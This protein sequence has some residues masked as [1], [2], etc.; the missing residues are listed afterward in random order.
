MGGSA[1]ERKVPDKRDVAGMQSKEPLEPSGAGAGGKAGRDTSV[2]NKKRKRPEAWAGA[3]VR[4][5]D[6]G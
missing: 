3:E 4:V 1:G 6:T 2:S 5:E